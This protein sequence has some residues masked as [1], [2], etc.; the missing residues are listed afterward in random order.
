MRC[1]IFHSAHVKVETELYYN[2]LSFFHIRFHLPYDMYCSTRNKLLN[3]HLAEFV[4][5]LYP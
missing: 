2:K 5:I 3:I 1:A 4:S